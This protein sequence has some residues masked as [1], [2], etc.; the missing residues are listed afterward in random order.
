MRRSTASPTSTSIRRSRRP[1]SP[2][3]A[4]GAATRGRSKESRSPSRT[5]SPGRAGALRRARSSTRT[6]RP[7][8]KTQPSSTR[9]RRR[10]PSCRSRRRC[11][12]STS[13]SAPR[14]VPGARPVIRGTSSTPRA[15]RPRDLGRRW[16]RASRRSPWGRT[17]AA[18]SAFPPRKTVS[19]ASGRRSAGSRAEKSPYRTS[20]PHRETFRR[21]RPFPERDRRTLRQGHGRDPAPSRLSRP[22]CGPLGMAYRRGLGRGRCQR[23]SV[24]EGR[25]VERPR[26]AARR[27]MRRGRGRLWLLEGPEVRLHARADGYVDR[28]FHRDIECPSRSALALYGGCARPGRTGRTAPGRGSRS[29]A[30]TAAPTSPGARFRER[31]PHPA[32][33][34]HGDAS[35]QGGHVQ[36]QGERSWMCGRAPGSG[37]R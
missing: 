11:R 15:G 9:S 33:A 30:G 23:H 24:G 29:V 6:R 22:I 12:N 37:S 25:N 18:R 1:S 35:R 19:T 7:Q 14:P 27:R 16:P 26:R 5:S 17:W 8:R 2:R 13:S 3:T 21:S 32:H 28:H 34:D 4:I 10:E 31:L 20:G 36:E